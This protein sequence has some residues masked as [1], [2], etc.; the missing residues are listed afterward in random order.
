MQLW[1]PPQPQ[2][3]L[4]KLLPVSYTHLDV[5]KRQ[6]QSAVKF[7]KGEGTAFIKAAR[8]ACMAAVIA[9][10]AA[11]AT[12]DSVVS[13]APLFWIMLGTGYGINF[14]KSSGEANGEA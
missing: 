8:L 7:V 6:V 11:A 4:R 3:L 2:K 5:Y 13:V 12:T 14:V 1:L 9:Y 10:M